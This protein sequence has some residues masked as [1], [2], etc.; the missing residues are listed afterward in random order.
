MGTARK[1]VVHN[2]QGNAPEGDP[3]LES[4]WATKHTRDTKKRQVYKWKAR[5]N[6]HRGKQ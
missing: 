5:L 1:T 6:V 3:V 4:V 2:S